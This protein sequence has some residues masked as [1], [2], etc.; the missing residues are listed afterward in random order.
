MERQFPHERLICYQLAVA[1]SRWVRRSDFP[2]GDAG[3]K[4]QAKHA[5]DRVALAVVE[6]SRAT[7]DDRAVHFLRAEACAAEVCAVLDLV[8]LEDGALIQRDLRRVATM[9]SGLRERRRSRSSGQE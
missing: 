6:G 7:G 1:I 8:E 4:Q 3:L 2:P 9:I 5:A